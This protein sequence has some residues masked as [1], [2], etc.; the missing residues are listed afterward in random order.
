MNP[1]YKILLQR[2]AIKVVVVILII[3]V[4]VWAG[5]KYWSKTGNNRSSIRG[6]ILGV[7]LENEQRV[8]A[9]SYDIG[10]EDG[11]AK[12][13]IDVVSLDE[14]RAIA[15]EGIKKYSKYV[16]VPSDQQVE[17]YLRAPAQKP[18]VGKQSPAQQQSATIRTLPQR[19]TTSTPAAKT[20]P[21]GGVV[22]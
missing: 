13:G 17:E 20:S 9:E 7:S 21:A 8:Q 18:N 6:N 11:L 15:D 14:L 16:A 12:S 3:A 4:S 10:R 22:K 5:S 1:K 19:P 2:I